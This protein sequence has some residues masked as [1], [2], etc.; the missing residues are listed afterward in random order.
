MT[1]CPTP[2]FLHSHIDF[3]DNFR[4]RCFFFFF[5]LMSAIAMNV[6]FVKNEAFIQRELK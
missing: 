3:F 6:A 1:I 2:S 4:R 5:F